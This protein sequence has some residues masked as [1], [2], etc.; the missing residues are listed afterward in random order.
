MMSIHDS[1]LVLI[2]HCWG[3]MSPLEEAG[4]GQVCSLFFSLPGE[5]QLRKG[6]LFLT[7]LRGIE[8][9]MAEKVQ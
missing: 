8:S 5:K 7:T 9:S 3:K 4:K 2:L 1:F 6:G